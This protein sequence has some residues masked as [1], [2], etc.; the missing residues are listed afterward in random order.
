MNCI[1]SIS[2]FYPAFHL[3]DE[4]RAIPCTIS[5]IE[6]NGRRYIKTPFAM[7]D[8]Y[9]DGE[10]DLDRQLDGRTYYASEADCVAYLEAEYPRW[11]TA[12]PI[13]EALCNAQRHY[14]S[15]SGPGR[16]ADAIGVSVFDVHKV[17]RGHRSC[18]KIATAAK[19][20]AKGVTQ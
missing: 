6:A 14:G 18:Y 3:G 2:G 17:A 13:M 11:R 9:D 7:L 19:K 12:Q 4:P 1:R 5:L 10:R 8:A 16:I 20:L 15:L